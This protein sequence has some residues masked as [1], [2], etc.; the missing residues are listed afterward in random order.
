M[1]PEASDLDY[2]TRCA[3]TGQE[4]E[5][6]RDAFKSCLGSLL[7]VLGELDRVRE[8]LAGCERACRDRGEALE[9]AGLL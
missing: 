8:Q 2:W 7:D 9:R 5:P 4:I 1:I 3:F 6:L